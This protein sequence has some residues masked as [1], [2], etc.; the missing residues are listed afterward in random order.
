MHITLS[1][2]LMHSDVNQLDRHGRGP[3]HLIASSGPSI[4]ATKMVSLLLQH[5][6]AIGTLSLSLSLSFSLALS[7]SLTH[8]HKHTLSLPLSFSHA[9]PLSLSHILSLAHTPPSLPPSFSLFLLLNY[10]LT[11]IDIHTTPS[12]SFPDTLTSSSQ[13]PLHIA[14]SHGHMTVIVA[15][16]EE[17]EADINLPTSDSGET[18]LM[19]S[20]SNTTTHT[21]THYYNKDT[22]SPTH[23]LTHIQTGS[24]CTHTQHIHTHL[25]AMQI[26][27][28]TH[29]HT[30]ALIC[31]TKN[32][33]TYMHT[34]SW[35]A[36]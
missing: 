36:Q 34:G 15:L 14:S 22:H 35:R 32:R 19:L 29:T 24:E 1:H 10:S 27:T 13:S 6:S 11:Y 4:H 20:V 5:G 21:L 17:G 33:H 8:S 7:S 23:T 28:C 18:P 16:V 26:C 3:L 30:H 25:Y 2:H 12:L 31:A 9:Q